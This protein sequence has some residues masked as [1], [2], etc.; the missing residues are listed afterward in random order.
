[1]KNQKKIGILLIA[2]LIPFVAINAQHKTKKKKA[3]AKKTTVAHKPTPP[4]NSVHAQPVEV[5]P[6]TVIWAIV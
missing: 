5:K 4:V 2:A 1:M 3:A 6:M